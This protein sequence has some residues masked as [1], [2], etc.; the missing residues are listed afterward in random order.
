M[1]TLILNVDRDDDFGRK[2]KVATPIIGVK[3]N[4]DAANKLGQSDPEDSDLNAIY[5]AIS[6]YNKLHD[7]NKEVEIAT[8]CGHINVGIKSDEILSQQLEMVISKTKAD[9]LILVTDGLEDEHILPIIQS[10]IKITSIKRVAVKQSKELEDTYFRLVKIL[11]DEKV[12]KQFILPIALVLIVWAFFV[13][14]GMAASGFG[15]ILLTLGLYLLIRVFR[16]ERNIATICREIKSGFL[17]GR[18]S[19]YTYIIA[20]VIIV[21]FGILA[22]YEVTN[23]SFTP[24][25]ELLPALYFI[26]K[27]I[28]GVVF[29]G[30]IAIFG[31]VVD[32][33]VK[34]KRAPWNYWIAPFSLFAF[35]F[36]SS[37]VF[38]ALYQALE[39]WPIKFNMNPFLTLSFIGYT[40]TGIL[41]ALVGAITYHYIKEIHSTEEKEFEI[42][43]QT[44]KLIEENQV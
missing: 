40:T 42:E 36:I 16:W 9:N 26:I 25:V 32:I 11:D 12:Q 38:S 28:W 8:I 34:D 31:R 4:I 5:S 10:R 41:I 30:L 23:T 1:K 43:E 37:A 24:E 44:S 29:A 2:A 22:Y 39:N 14:L 15:A 21:A 35:G 27:I 6:T 3:D 17:T 19:I 33:Y 20:T 7:E 18:L 13:L